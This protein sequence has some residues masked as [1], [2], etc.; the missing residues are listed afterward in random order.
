MGALLS[1]ANELD[2]KDCDQHKRADNDDPLYRAGLSQTQHQEHG[3]DARN[4]AAKHCSD[5]PPVHAAHAPDF[6]T[7]AWLAQVIVAGRGAA[8]NAAISESYRKYGL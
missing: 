1:R 3:R 8:A 2:C 5:Y 6:A 7:R 4:P